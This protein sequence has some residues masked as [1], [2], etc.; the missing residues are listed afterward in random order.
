MTD[1]DFIEQVRRRSIDVAAMIGAK[2]YDT[3]GIAALTLARDA[4]AHNEQAN[5]Q[6]EQAGAYNLNAL[7][8]NPSVAS[9]SETGWERDA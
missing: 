7:Q 8:V 1:A 5:M 2:Q 9:N 6:Q 4:A 3:A